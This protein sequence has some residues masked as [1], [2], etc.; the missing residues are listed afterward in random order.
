MKLLSKVSIVVLSS[1]ALAFVTNVN[2]DP[3]S[4]DDHKNIISSHHH[5]HHNAKGIE[6]NHKKLR[7]IHEHVKRNSD[8][9]DEI[10]SK[11]DKLERKH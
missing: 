11:I 9:L 1:A 2:A 3:V 7:E 6:N 8:K 10:N 5:L 4:G